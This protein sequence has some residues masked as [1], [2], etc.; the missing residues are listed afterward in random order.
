[1]VFETVARELFSK[2]MSDV[3]LVSDGIA[4]WM[5]VENSKRGCHVANN[6]RNWRRTAKA[7]SGPD[8]IQ[9]PTEGWRLVLTPEHTLFFLGWHLVRKKNRPLPIFSQ[10]WSRFCVGPLTQLSGVLVGHG[11]KKK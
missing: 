9:A 4:H 5:G 2:S 3:E 7:N 10:I 8:Q 6:T 11:C 1:M